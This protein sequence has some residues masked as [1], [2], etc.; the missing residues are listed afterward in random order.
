MDEKYLSKP[1][2]LVRV[3][4]SPLCA[5][6][7]L[8]D[9]KFDSEP[10]ETDFTATRIQKGIVVIADDTHSTL[11]RVVSYSPGNHKGV[12]VRV[13]SEKL[14]DKLNREIKLAQIHDARERLPRLV[15]V[16][17]EDDENIPR[18]YRQYHG[19]INY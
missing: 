9:A 7:D 6:G 17:D 13:T 3:R 15:E 8:A 11:Y 2:N 12:A 5:L 1:G 14:A 16:E 10:G 18:S 4:F 19:E